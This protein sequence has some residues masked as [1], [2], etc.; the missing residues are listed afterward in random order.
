M[1]QLLFITLAP[2]GVFTLLPK[3]KVDLHFQTFSNLMTLFKDKNSIKVYEEWRGFI[4]LKAIDG[5]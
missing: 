5:V 1:F 4:I 3:I 2:E